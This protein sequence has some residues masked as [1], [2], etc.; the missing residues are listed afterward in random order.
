MNHNSGEF[1]LK[2]DTQ[3]KET[4][5]PDTSPAEEK[6]S[7][8]HHP[9][10]TKH[11]YDR[12]PEIK[13]NPHFFSSFCF[14]PAGVSFST[15]QEDEEIIL[16]IRRDFITNVPWIAGALG[17]IAIPFL[18][19][20]F[21]DFLFPFLSLSNTTLSYIL[22]FYFLIIFGFI[23]LKFSLWYFHVSFVTNLRIVDVDVHGILIR[24]TTET[25]LELVEDI[26][27]KQHGFIPSLFDYGFVHIQ[28][29]GALQNIE[30]DKAP[31]P[32]RIAEIIGDRIGG[33]IK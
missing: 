29:A 8:E 9:S 22:F 13:K 5:A 10:I 7:S 20:P 19:A 4:P 3:D 17:L 11:K 1:D 30:F 33:K 27:H 24:D 31:Q 26:S 15:Q 14:Y 25:R 6:A 12:K 16:L 28:T 18:V 21:Y 23:I 32:A 2:K